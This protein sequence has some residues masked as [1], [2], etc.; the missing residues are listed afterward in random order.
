MS[1]HL[2]TL[3]VLVPVLWTASVA[4][5]STNLS[6]RADEYLTKLTREEKFSGSVLVATNGN[7]VFAK[8]FPEP[9]GT[10]IVNRIPFAMDLPHAAGALYSTVGDLLIW[11]QALYSDRLVTAKS[12][13]AMFT[14]YKGWGYCYG[15]LH[16]RVG[17]S[18][19]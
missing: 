12:L 5:D 10:N 3:F 19:H 4:A 18:D 2:K 17:E 8:G 1:T 6:S 16:G 13:E 14:E 9:F 15:W 11:D 7:I